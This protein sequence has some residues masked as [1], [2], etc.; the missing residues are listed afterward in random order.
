MEIFIRF[1][2]KKLTYRVVY[3]FLTP[4]IVLICCFTKAEAKIVTAS[5]SFVVSG[6][7]TTVTG[8]PL[9][10]VTVME[11]GTQTGVTTDLSGNYKLTVSGISAVLVFRYVGYLEKQVDVNALAV[12][13]VQLTADQKTLNDVVV[14]AYGTQKR[15]DI[16]GAVADINEKDLQDQPVA[17]F[18]QQLQ[19]KTAGVVVSQQT[20]IPGQG[21]SIVIRQSTDLN[22]DSQP[23]YVIDG[24]P[25][26]GDNSNV[27]NIN[28]VEIETISILKDAASTALYGSRAANGVVIITTKHAKKGES[29]IG[30][31]MNYGL[32]QVPQKGRPNM[33]NA[34]Q[35]AQ[36]ENDV[37]T[38]EIALGQATAIPSVYL[39]PAQYAGKGTNWYNVLLRT[40]P[41]QSYNLSLNS[42]SDKSSTSAT[43]GYL[44]QEGVLIESNYKRFSLRVNSDYKFNDRVT[45]GVSVAP[46]YTTNATPNS[47]GNIFSGGII[48]NAIAS[49]PLAP[50][51]NPDGSIPLT[52]TSPGL[53]PNPNWYLVAQQVKNNT[54]TGRILANSF[55]NVELLKGL[56]FR[57]SL[58]VDYTNAQN[59][60]WNP[61][62]AGSLFSPPPV[63]A[64]ASS[65]SNIFYTWLSENTLDYKKSVG[66]HNFDVF[67]GYTA[68]K[69]HQNYNS[70]SGYGFRNDAVSSL[71][72]ATQFNNPYYDIEEWSLTS[73]VSRLN[74]NYKNK[75][76]L[77][78]SFRRDGSSRFAPNTKF[79]NFPG[80]SAGWNVYQ[81]N[82]IS[83]IPQI[84]NLK[85]R[86]SYALNG[87][88]NIG[89][90]GF[91]ANT[92]QANYAFNN[93][94]ASGTAVSNLGNN[95]LSWEQSKQ[96]DIGLELG[97]FKNRVS[98]TYDYF[99]KIINNN[100]YNV[101]VAQ[102]SG[103]SSIEANVGE[104][105][106]HGHEFSVISQNLTG[107]VRWSTNFNISFI[108]NKIVNLGPYGQNLP[109]QTNG[110]N[111][112]EVGQPIGSFYGYKRIG[113]Y[114]NQA[115]FNN[116]PKYLQG[117][118]LYASA[119]GTVK[120]ADVNHDGVI[121]QNDRTIIG[122]P[123]PKFTYGMT[124]NIAYKNFDLSISLAGSYGNDIMN[125]TLEYIQNLDGVFNV[126]ADVANRWK[127]PSDPGAG[128]FPRILV[129]DALDRTANSRWVTSGSYLTI[130][131]IALGYT[132]P[133]TD[134]KYFKSIR[135][136]GSIQQVWVFT[137]YNGANPEV[138]AYGTNGLNQGVDYTSYPVPR[139]FSAGLNMNLK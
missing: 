120:F 53:F 75:Y 138:S 99:H 86:A 24:F 7:V 83:R 132:I 114:E 135:F 52:A 27:A 36:Y 136:Y 88:F 70:Q 102:E 20:G 137:G 42:S 107:K 41:I 68:Q 58:G 80:I 15:T 129:G 98:F 110:T 43:L 61:S 96:L 22:G 72:A 56:V 8:E 50:Y 28:P 3:F 139:T 82:F 115:D 90:Y 32:Q 109:T 31:N 34:E 81:E 113:I 2:Q 25:M 74:Y 100:L 64:T 54:Q 91:Q 78:A 94:L 92:G 134:N 49:S 67:V 118:L 29:L 71:A 48:Q 33:M 123:N 89:N 128:V 55:I 18:A 44:D 23:L 38:Q 121:D 111:I 37:F 14:V 101:P 112:E 6:K 63:T 125:R 4:L 108:R 19:G 124:N 84:S 87:N 21:L 57:T 69:Y 16:T 51:I 1:C 93:T 46:S 103:F 131:N 10:G 97:I 65:T 35:F 116:S 13:N 66:D 106:F 60:T 45:A 133:V 30:F 73:L 119:V 17:Q 126:T 11:K 117:G 77:S 130:K 85:L 47:D 79:G 104:F 39:N 127:S 105:E 40:A 5:N 76:I 12:I 59:Q 122:N 26:T 95:S 9:V 62:T